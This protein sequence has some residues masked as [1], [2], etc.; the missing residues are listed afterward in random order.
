VLEKRP[1]AITS[2]ASVGSTT[3]LLPAGAFRRA[4]FYFSAELR[5]WIAAQSANRKPRLSHSTPNASSTFPLRPS[6]TPG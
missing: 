2:A 3:M 1:R 5:K 6:C 4:G